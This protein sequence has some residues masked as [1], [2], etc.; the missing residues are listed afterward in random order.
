MS[1]LFYIHSGVY[2]SIPI[3]QFIPLLLFPLGKH[4]FVFYICDS[5]L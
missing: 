1:Y 5:V 4:K 3:S 2:M